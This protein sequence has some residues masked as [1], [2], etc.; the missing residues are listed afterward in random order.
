VKKLRL[1]PKK[2]Y[3][4]PS[5]VLGRV[6]KV[7]NNVGKVFIVNLD[8]QSN[9]AVD[10]DF[11]EKYFTPMMTIGEVGKILDKKPHTIRTYERRGLINK[12]R[13]FHAGS[14]TVKTVRLYSPDEVRD[15]LE[16]FAERRGPGRPAMT[17]LNKVDRDRVEMFLNAKYERK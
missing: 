13:Q 4:L 9:E 14:G 7:N 1:Q 15:L 16:F 5:G 8:T 6:I 12:A 10:L 2:L 11:A 3:L 17:N